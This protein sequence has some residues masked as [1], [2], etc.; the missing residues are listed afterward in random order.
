MIRGWIDES[1]M[2]KLT[3]A[4]AV[5]FIYFELREARR[6]EGDIDKIR[7]MVTKMRKAFGIEGIELSRIYSDVHGGK[8]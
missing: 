5:A 1:N 4:E 2:Y 3:R 6:H 8:K 7:E